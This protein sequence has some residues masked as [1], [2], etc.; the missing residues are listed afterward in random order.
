MSANRITTFAPNAPVKLIT[1]YEKGNLRTIE[2]RRKINKKYVY[3]LLVHGI[4]PTDPKKRRA[5]FLPV[6]KQPR[7][8]RDIPDH[9]QWW[10]KLK[11][12]YRD[13]LIRC[14]YESFTENGL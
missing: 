4:E 9:V 13:L 7:A 1:M 8:E 10:R 12:D 11:K 3:N 5:L 6:E 2:A 14:E